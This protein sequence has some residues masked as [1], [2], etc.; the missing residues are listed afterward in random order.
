MEK[1]FKPL[2]NFHK[3]FE[4][5]KEDEKKNLE[6]FTKFAELGKLR[7]SIFVVANLSW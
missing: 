5:K 3:C 1:I 4:G 7:K 2:H 6:I